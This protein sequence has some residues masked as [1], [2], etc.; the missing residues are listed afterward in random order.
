MTGKYLVRSSF[1]DP[2]GVN[3]HDLVSVM[4]R[5]QPVRDKQHGA[6]LRQPRN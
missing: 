2:S 6:P 3:D 4:N 1:D 5:T